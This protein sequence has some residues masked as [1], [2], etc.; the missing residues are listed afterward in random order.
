MSLTLACDKIHDVAVIHTYFCDDL[1]QDASLVV[2]EL[3]I[4]L[5]S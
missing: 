3:D 4:G 2:S 5:Y 1:I